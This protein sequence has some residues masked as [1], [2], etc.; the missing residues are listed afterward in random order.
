MRTIRLLALM[1]F[2]TLV[3]HAQEFITW[4]VTVGQNKAGETV[5]TPIDVTVER[6]VTMM[7]IMDLPIYSREPIVGMSFKG[8]NPGAGQTRHVRVELLDSYYKFLNGLDGDCIFDGDC[9]IPQGGSINEPITLINL[10]FPTPLRNDRQHFY[11]K[12][13]STG[14]AVEEP[15]VFD[16]LDD[17]GGAAV[18]LTAQAEVAYLRGR[19]TSQDGFPVAGANVC[20]HSDGNDLI[21]NFSYNAVTDADGNYSVRVEHGSR[22]YLLKVAA[23]GYADY[24][25]DTPFALEEGRLVE[26]LATADVSLW[27]RLDFTAGQRATIILPD[28]P[29]PSWGRYYRLD[30]RT[31]DDVY[32]FEREL[33]PQAN[34][35]Y[36][37]FPNQ[38]FSINLSDYSGR[39]LPEAGCQLLPEA[40]ETWPWGFHGTYQSCIA[41]THS[42]ALYHVVLD[43]TPD[44]V[45]LPNQH[46]RVGA[47]RAFLVANTSS[48]QQFVESKLMFVG[49]TDDISDAVAD[50]STS[51]TQLFDLQGRR[52]VGQPRRGL[53]IRDGRKTVVR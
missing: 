1:L 18:T 35:P 32:V 40:D 31:A 25:I 50:G 49:E 19:I 14:T 3:A 6:S 51:H 9:L 37:I 47:F 13:E 44:C 33:S 8:F 10:P 41:R 34:V 38:D 15:L 11:L 29:D 7:E 52:V 20:V 46:P 36:V 42:L 12:I 22:L 43:K 45:N 30:R 28:A 2:G 48:D 53:Y 26:W 21:D 16:V 5:A 23:P 39:E 4:E 27:N 24:V 17:G